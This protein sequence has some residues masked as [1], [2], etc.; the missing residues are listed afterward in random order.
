MDGKRNRQVDQL[1]HTLINVALPNYIANHR[2]Q[3]FGFHGPDLA[4]QKRNEINKRADKITAEMIEEI[5]PGRLFTVKSETTPGLFYTVDLEAYKCQCPS[6]PA[7]SFC[8]HICGVENNFP[9]L[10]APRSLPVAS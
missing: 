6:F 5:E 1:I 8:K 7:I 2:V 4:L 9:D 3:Q 10:V